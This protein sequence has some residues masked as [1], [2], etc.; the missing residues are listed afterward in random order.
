MKTACR[1][2]LIQFPLLLKLFSSH[3]IP[4]TA[5]H[6]TL[7][8][9]LR[10]LDPS[11]W[12]FRGFSANDLPFFPSP[13]SQQDASLCSF[14]LLCFP[15]AL[16]RCDGHTRAQHISTGHN[17]LSVDTQMYLC[18]HHCVVQSLCGPMDCST[19][20]L[21]VHHQLPEFTQTHVH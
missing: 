20:G 16:M 7:G 17:L 2:M 15:S 5:S 4:H 8:S 19:P 3:L 13:E 14:S 11:F 21:P 9:G 1:T 6:F 10:R 12:N 18:Y